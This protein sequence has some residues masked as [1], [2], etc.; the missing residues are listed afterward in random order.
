MW[1][2]LDELIPVSTSGR[3]GNDVQ[4][5]PGAGHLME[6]DAPDAVTAALRTFLA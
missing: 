2:D 3:W 6:W 5:V 4:V 1:G